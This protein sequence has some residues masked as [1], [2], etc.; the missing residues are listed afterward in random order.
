MYIEYK[1]VLAKISRPRHVAVATQPVRRLQI[2]P[3]VHNQWASP[4]TLPSYI[5]VRAIVWAC[6][7]GQTHTETHRR[8]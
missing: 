7:R 1:H 3:T 4:T 8:A 2:R 6:G 5:R